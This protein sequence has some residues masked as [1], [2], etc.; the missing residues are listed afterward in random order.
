MAN[1]AK[2]LTP[3]T[4]ELGGKSPAVVAPDYPIDKA[5]QRILWAKTFNAGQIC[6][7][8]DYL[9]LPEGQV[10][11][12][13]QAAKAYCAR[14][15]P[16]INGGDY[17]AVIDQRSYDR[18][19]AALDDAKAKGA[20]LV[21]LIEA[22]AP[23]ASRRIMAPTI[24]LNPTED[25]DLMQREI[26]G[27]ILPIKTYRAREEVTTYIN[28]RPRPLAFY[29]YTNERSL[30][31][32]YIYNTLSGGVTINDSLLHVSVHSLPFGGIGNSGMGHY[33]GFEGFLTFSKLRPVLYQGPIRAIN[34][35]LPPY[36]A[37]VEK[38]LNMMI[39]MKS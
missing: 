38:M 11:A 32:W 10:D 2:N 5:A 34:M 25:M 21:N 39:R 24:V 14:H 22:Q 23:D 27:P 1:A 12:F 15:Y 13:V 36:G 4:L 9:F 20:T 35:M 28:D 8:V 31:D 37:K 19:Q 3:V 26:F 33:H 30:A 18:L 6:T 17:T 29:A 16:N 7:N